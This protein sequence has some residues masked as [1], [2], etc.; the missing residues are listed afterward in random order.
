[1]KIVNTTFIQGIAALVAAFFISL[2]SHFAYA[3]MFDFSSFAAAAPI[4]TAIT[5]PDSIT[6]TNHDSSGIDI[7]FT[8]TTTGSGTTE[9]AY[10]SAG[11]GIDA[12]FF[13]TLDDV[14]DGPYGDNITFTMT[15]SK[16]INLDIG[17]W[18]IDGDDRFSITA[19]TPFASHII[20]PTLSDIIVSNTGPTSAIYDG[21]GT[22]DTDGDPGYPGLSG[23]RAEGVL[24]SFSYVTSITAVFDTAHLTGRGGA[25]V[26]DEFEVAVP[27]P[28]TTALVLLGG[29]VAYRNRRGVKLGKPVTKT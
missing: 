19:D 4:G 23:P 3:A 20:D 16:P 1:M 13:G 12:A 29:L 8:A 10:A 7:T 21:N 14:D 28:S 11:A 2:P 22:T 26:F 15:F 25:I 24:A 17:F 27:E 6:L 18:D 5:Y 9:G